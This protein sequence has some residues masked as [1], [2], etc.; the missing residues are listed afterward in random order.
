MARPFPRPVAAADPLGDEVADRLTEAGAAERFVRL[1]GAAVRFI[2]PRGHWLVWGDH[3][4]VRDI[5]AAVPRLGLEFVHDW[6]R[7]AVELTSRER[8]EAV[9]TFTM[10]LERR[11]ALNSVLALAATMKPVADDGTGWDAA[12][13]LLGVPNGV[14][15]LRTGT[16]RPGSREDKITMSTAVP[17]DADATCHRWESFLSDI[18]NGADDLVEFIWR[19]IGYSLTG[20]TG[21]QCLFL[22]FGTGANGKSTLLLILKFVLGD[23][24][25]N[26]PFSTIEMNQRG[27]IPND[28]AALAGRRFV[29]AAETNDGTRLNESR[30][31]ALTG[32]DPVTA[33]FLHAEFFEFEPV[34]KFW[35]SV[36]HKPTVKDDS[37]GFWRRIRLVPFRQTFDVNPKLADE[38]RAEAPGVLAWAVRGCLAWQA[39]GLNPPAL[40]TAATAEYAQDSDALGAFVDDALDLEPASELLAS[41]LYEHYCMWAKKQGLGDRERLTATAFGRK[42]TERFPKIR[43]AGCAWYQGVAR[44]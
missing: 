42:M 2:H 12:P 19:V 10:K 14:V 43:R 36:N 6:Q 28:L 22:C 24:A 26:M 8:R 32:S 35:L 44:R 18:F 29:M 25:W 23:H 9:L 20:D 37:R 1:H 16:L 30:I 21:E 5:D 33:R 3:R 7:E 41:E 4:W 13:M 40:V 11:D 39:Q 17:F 15:D 38:L 34:A 27:S 31:K